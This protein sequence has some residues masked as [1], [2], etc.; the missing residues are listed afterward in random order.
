MDAE[1]RSSVRELTTV[2]A[3]FSALTLALTYPQ[4]TQLGTHVG[5]HYD[6]LFSVWRLA[7]IAHQL[8]RDPLHLFDANIFHPEPNTLAYSDATLLMG[9]IASPLIWSGVPAVVAYNALVLTSF[10][11][12]GVG[13]YVL[14]RSLGA[15]P[16]GALVAGIVF[17]FQPYRFAHYP[18]LELLWTCWIP[19]ALWALHRAIATRQTRYGVWLGIFVALQAW[20]CLYYAVFLATGLVVVAMALVI[21]RPASAII[22]LWRP[23]ASAIGIALPLILGY[24]AP[25]V[26]SRGLVGTRT[27]EDV[28]EWSPT[29]ANYAVPQHRNWLYGDP[30]NDVDPFEHVLFPGIAAVILAATGILHRPRRHAIAYAVLLVL[31]L[32]LSLGLNGF[33]YPLLYEWV[34]PYQGLRVPARM[35]VMV[36]LALSVLAAFGA[37]SL[38][39][40]RRGFVA[41]IVLA[42]VAVVETVSLPLPL[43]PTPAAPTK[44]SAWL[45]RQP[46]APVLEWPTAVPEHLGATED[47]RYM[48]YSTRHWLPLVNGYS[49]HYPDSFL[50]LLHD[51]R[52]FPAPAAIEHLGVRRVRYVILHSQPDEKKYVAAVRQLTDHPKLRFQFAENTGWEEVSVY[53]L[54]PD[55]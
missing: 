44:T 20:S 46:V 17:A 31:A 12:A 35:F 54:E 48:Y 51:I 33:L 4:V 42:I 25:Y 53:V 27:V 50:R 36:S 43:H 38:S 8:P 1:S 55:R 11:A 26:E 41:V 19:L 6:A 23:A 52:S 22:S 39:A 49:G 30:P 10:A 37:T 34:W 40:S 16:A 14:G 2:A 24:A 28:Q 32:D 5:V 29:I 15:S 21:G 7:W 13:A 3:T 45:A 18:Q 47:A 9:L